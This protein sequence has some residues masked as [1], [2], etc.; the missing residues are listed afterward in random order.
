[1]VVES[2]LSYQGIRVAILIDFS[3]LLSSQPTEVVQVLAEGD[4]TQ[5]I[6]Q[7]LGSEMHQMLVPMHEQVLAS[8]YRELAEVLK[9][10]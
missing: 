2:G 7:R 6:G 8:L 5:V 1:M 9:Q 10:A 3:E 4:G